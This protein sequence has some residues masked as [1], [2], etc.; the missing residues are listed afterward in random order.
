MAYQNKTS[1]AL[2]EEFQELQLK[3]EELKSSYDK[4]ISARAY[5]EERLHK[6]SEL[7][8]SFNQFSIDFSEQNYDSILDFIVSSCKKLFNVR[9]V[10][11]S[12]YD[13]DRSEL[14]I[15]ASTATGA[16]NSK[17]LKYLGNALKNYRTALD[18]ENYSMILESGTRVYS[19]LHD[20]SFGQIPKIVGVAIEKLFN[21]G[22]FQGVALIDKGKLFGTL[23]IAGYAGQEE[24]EAD[25]LKIF[26]ELT[27]NLLRRKQTEAK[28]QASEDKFRK[29]F[30]TNPDAMT[31]NRLSDGMFVSVNEGFT[32]I[33][34]YSE[35]DTRGRTSVDLNIWTHADQREKIA[36]ALRNGDMVKNMMDSFRHKDGT[37]RYGTISATMINLDNIPHILSITRDI[38]NIKQAEEKLLKSE[39]KYKLLAENISDVIWVMDAGTMRFTYMSPSVER[40]RGYTAEEVI[41]MPVT[42]ALTPEDAEIIT[43]NTQIGAEAILSGKEAPG[44]YDISEV[45]QPCKDG[46]SVLTEVIT[47]FLINPD[48]GR[49]EV[50]G[51]TRDIT[52]RKIAEKT[53]KENDRLLRESQNIARL[54]SFVWDLSSNTWK[55]SGILDEILGIDENYPHTFEGWISRVHPRWRNILTNFMSAK[56]LNKYKKFDREFEIVRYSDNV[57]RWVHGVTE[58]EFDTNGKPVKLIGVMIDITQWKQVEDEVKKL[59]A[60]LEE[61]VNER[62]AQLEAAN[63]ELQA[64]AY[65]VSHDL[66]APLRAIDGFSRFLLE[67][68]SSKLDAEGQRLLGLVRSNTQKMDRLITDILA[69]SRITRSE[70]KKSKIDMTKMAM[71]MFNEAATPEIKSKLKIIVEELPDTYAD[72]T[73][74]K[75]VW[76]NLLSNAIKFSSLKSKPLVKIGGYSEDKFNVYYVRDN[77]VGFNPEYSNKLFGVFQRLHKANEF[78]G[79]GVGLAIVQRIIHRHG[80]KVWADS[81]E[82]KGATFYF[83]LPGRRKEQ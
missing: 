15:E 17:I 7:L 73:Y 70:H 24:I 49:V 27:S 62:T 1:K 46:S 39:E 47:T 82:G 50:L 19:S 28:L 20:I 72:P 32:K 2:I 44:K 21:V 74:I 37:V 53:L 36:G 64:F 63:T 75:Q 56:S 42:E 83:S 30:D 66:R 79:N 57:E 26:S 18:K 59:N 11:L 55:S 65:S 67:D 40:L 29:A 16:E 45:K 80:G 8:S 51:V 5:V 31:I 35:E 38:T 3:Y 23:V 61:R 14:V 43:R 81:T 12:S 6:R 68:Y 52:Q 78:E 58:F 10:W 25:V 77:G 69:L 13:E 9:V 4:D 48:N 33:T 76:V 54:G 71:S 60:E 41:S 34:G 22:W